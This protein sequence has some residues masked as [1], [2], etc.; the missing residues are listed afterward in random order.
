MLQVILIGCGYALSAALQP[1]PLQ[2]FFLAKVAQ[3]GWKRT[4]PAALAPLVSD[5]PIALVAILFLKVLPVNLRDYLQV[6]GG[7]LLLVFARSAFRNWRDDHPGEEG[8]VPATPRT[9]LQAA[10]VNLLNPNP[11][12]G[13][14]LVMG[15]ALLNAW[16]KAPYLALALLVA[17]YTTMISTSLVIIYLMGQALLLGDGTRRLLSL[18]SALLLAG[19]GLYFLYQA[20]SRL[21]AL[22]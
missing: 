6:A 10:L 5:G 22:L 20:G 11:Y 9:L 15:P 7:F 21:V 12:L 17:F 3:N 14:S 4:L 2:A 16:E 13:W 1:G 19:L 18:V 8:S